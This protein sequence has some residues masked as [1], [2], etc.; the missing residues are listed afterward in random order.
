[1]NIIAEEIVLT[2]KSLMFCSFSILS[3]ATNTGKCWLLHSS[4]SDSVVLYHIPFDTGTY[5]IH[6]VNDKSW[7]QDNI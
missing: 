6:W 4:F 1:M 2:A 5:K 7:S 3:I